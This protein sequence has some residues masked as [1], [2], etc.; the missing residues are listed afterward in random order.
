M[1]R[2]IDLNNP[3][4]LKKVPPIKWQGLSDD[5]QDPTLCKFK[6]PEYGIRAPVRNLMTYC[7]RGINTVRLII[8]SWAPPDPTGDKNP[9]DAYIANVCM[10]T[11]FGADEV[12]DLDQA[13]IMRPLIKAIIRQEN[14]LMPYS[15]EVINNAMRLAGISDMDP[16]PVMKSKATQG[17]TI[18]G[19]G[20]TV[21]AAAEGV[22]QLQDIQTTV[23]SG[24]GFM[25]W[26]L[27]YGPWCAVAFVVA[28]GGLAMYD[29]WQ[30]RKRLGI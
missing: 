18:A 27:S 2:E 6:S 3:C 22:R 30:R 20:T 15:D 23:D 21:A 13:E 11:S 29:Y 5:Q 24:V 17:A 7:N 9:T 28:G 10:W 19:V 25:H 1:T 14:G 26:L 12:L 8:K 4:G 16:P